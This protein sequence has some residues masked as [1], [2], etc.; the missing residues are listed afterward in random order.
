MNY[1][2]G[3][4]SENKL[5]SKFKPPFS[6]QPSNFRP[7]KLMSLMCNPMN[8]ILKKNNDFSK[9]ANLLDFPIE[10]T[11]DIKLNPKE[12]NQISDNEKTLWKNHED[13]DSLYKNNTDE[14]RGNEDKEQKGFKNIE[15]GTK[16][17]LHKSFK[18]PFSKICNEVHEKKGLQDALKPAIPII[19]SENLEKNN[20][21]TLKDP[22]PNENTDL[23]NNLVCFDKDNT[24]STSC[25][26]PNPP[27][28][29]NFQSSDLQLPIK[30]QENKP[31]ETTTVI[32]KSE[33]QHDE[34]KL[35]IPPLVP[36]KKLTSFV[37][38][39]LNPNIKTNPPA[40]TEDKTL[41][42]IYY[43]VIYSHKHKK[44]GKSEDGVL[45]LSLKKMLLIDTTGKQISETPNNLRAKCFRDGEEIDIGTRK[46]IV[47]KKIPRLE[48]ISGRCFIAQTV[49]PVEIPKVYKPIVKE[50]IVPDG[51]FVIDEEQK[52]YVEPFLA[53]KLRPHQKEGV[54]FM[55][56]CIAGK[57][58]EGYFGCIL[59]DSMGLGKT[60]QAITLLYTILRKDATYPTFASKG[61]I[62]SPATLV[63]NWRDEVLK[64]LGPYKMSPIV[65]SGSG[66]QK[67][68]LLTIFESGPSPL[69]IISYES[70][71]K[72]SKTMKN[73][74]NVIICDEG[75]LLKN[76]VTQK[77]C[78]ISMMNCKRRILLTGTPLQNYLSEFYAC[79]T[80]V[81]PGI[82][83][84]PTTFNR[85]YADPIL[86]AQEPN[87]NNT[88]RDLAWGRSEE[89][90]RVTAQ[91]ILRRTGS[92]LESVLP[93]RNEF[94]V[95]CKCLPL[96][97]D[98]YSALL[99]SRLFSLALEGGS[100]A[101]ALALT[102][103]LRKLVNHPDLVYLSKYSNPEIEASVK[104]TLKF[105]PADYIKDVD[106]TKH[107]TKLKFF[108]IIMTQCIEKNEKLV[109]VSCYTKTLDLIE[110]HCRYKEYGFL[111]L[112]GSTLTKNRMQL[113]TSF[114][115]SPNPL[116]FLLSTKAGGCGLNLI[117][118]NRLILYDP[119]W[120]PSS[121]KQAMGRIWRDGQKKSVFI[122]RLFLSGTIEEKIYQR[123][124]AKENLSSTVVDAKK[125]VSKF[126]KEDLKE[127]FS[128]TN[129][130]TSIEN[131]D[132]ST[133]EES[134][135]GLMKDFIDL[136]KKV[137]ADWETVK[138]EKL[139]FTEAQQENVETEKCI[140][141]TKSSAKKKSQK[142]K[143]N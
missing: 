93:P 35:P 62:V 12:D 24:I 9:P 57:R 25:K 55:Y 103:I 21:N 94:L 30:N 49:Q 5:T 82:L 111:R 32:E 50:V 127:I 80:L 45:V 6:N 113:V 4:T 143:N 112:D 76:C 56:D 60:L 64:W 44:K 39:P 33:H 40:Q 142:E 34:N 131:G 102:S 106:R 61:I 122:Y 63:D 72:Y 19:K 79:V 100:A 67:K 120:N 1:I 78:A 87:A 31:N 132:C 22:N 28:S 46:V 7:G 58:K 91:F 114:N 119:D 107:S 73:I 86:R 52:V 11:P 71:V 126:S 96:Q 133:E 129:F 23:P 17:A 77:N 121:D 97:R 92:I 124:T 128:L 104:K 88:I 89:L 85:L 83:G 13:K 48:Y 108:D 59:A 27:N 99:S 137:K 135:L 75:H 15:D 66:K 38:H 65:C 54:Q 81:N 20:L 136:H 53:E 16:N 105:F 41:N 26:L 51:A 109:V 36:K 117:G 139:D 10:N 98:V 47:Q 115:N 29:N 8:Q 138:M 42:E 14:V 101:N 90:W 70:F 18:P 84:D 2:K 95:F 140:E 68:N 110:Q 130:C 141:L 3:G 125:A 116:A 134:L 43:E 118:A 69:L 37:F 123:Q 74:C